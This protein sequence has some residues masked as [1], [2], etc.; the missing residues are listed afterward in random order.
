MR[1]ILIDA[2]NRQLRE[3]FID[4]EKTLDGL[5]EAVGGN[6]EVAVQFDDGDCV[7]VNE[8]GLF[9]SN[10]HWFFVEGAHQ[11]FA[12]NGVVSCINEAGD[13]IDARIS[14]DELLPKIQWMTRKE[15]VAWAGGR[16]DD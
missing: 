14:I 2:K 15:A 11:P 4:D 1:V 13:T 7:Y 8:E 6:I 5:Q 16:T 12:G 9:H 10:D 3:D